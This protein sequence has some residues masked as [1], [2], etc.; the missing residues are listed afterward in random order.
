VQRD[1]TYAQPPQ[2]FWNR[3]DGSFAETGKSAGEVFQRPLVGRGL[4]VGD[5]DG[6]GDLDAVVTC[7]GGRPVLLR[8]DQG[9]GHH[10]VRFRLVGRGGNRDALGA[11]VAILCGGRRQV[12]WVRTGSSY[13]SQS[14]LA[15]TFGLG[16][17]TELTAAEVR[18]PSGD[19]EVFAVGG[20]DRQHVLEQGRGTPAAR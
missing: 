11:Q 7:N 10:F 17:H 8:N 13:L 3:G 16:R 20:V 12:R 9:L 6:D 1:V 14:E 18:W 4:A 15:V 19:L 5:L 2:L